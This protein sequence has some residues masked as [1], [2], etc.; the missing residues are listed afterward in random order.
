MRVRY[1]IA[2]AVMLITGC[3]TTHYQEPTSGPRAR[4]RFATDGQGTVLRTYQG[5]SCSGEETEWL[6]I[7]NGLQLFSSTK[8][9]GMPLLR[10][11]KGAATELYVDASKPIYALFDGSNM[12]GIDTFRCG[13]PFNYQF[14][15]GSDYEVRFAWTNQHC[16]VQIYKIVKDVDGAYTFETAGNFDSYL[17]VKNKGCMDA[18]HKIRL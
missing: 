6:R 16:S 11:D 8:R 2:A 9:L 17:D 13:V 10:D 5:Q 18:F 3:S 14:K 15:D 12:V 4:V 1:L 7:S